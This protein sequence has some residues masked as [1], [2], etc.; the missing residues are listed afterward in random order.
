[1]VHLMD[2]WKKI[3]VKGTNKAPENYMESRKSLKLQQRIEFHA[4]F[5]LAPVSYGFVW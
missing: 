3:I 2:P 1:M 4:Y 5:I